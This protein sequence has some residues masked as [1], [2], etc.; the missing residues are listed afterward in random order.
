MNR[1][2]QKKIALLTNSFHTGGGLE[3]I[4]QIVRNLPEFQFAVFG[5]G[6][7]DYQKFRDLPHVQVIDS[8]YSPSLIEVYQPDLVHIHHLKPLLNL[9]GAPFRSYP[10]PI[11]FTIHGVH[12]HKYEFLSGIRHQLS[13]QLRFRLE[14]Y[15]YRKVNKLITVSADDQEFVRQTYAVDHLIYIPN[16]LDFE[17]INPQS[18]PS[19][20]EIR[21]QLSLSNSAFAF[22]TIARFDFAKGYDVLIK[23]LI[24]QRKELLR[25]N[26]RFLFL[27]NGADRKNVQRQIQRFDLDELVIFIDPE[28]PNYHLL[29]A[30]DAFILPSRWEGLPLTL[31]EAGAFSLPVLASETYGIRTIIQHQKNGLLFKNQNSSDLGQLLMWTLNNRDQFKRMGTQL[32]EDVRKNYDLK[33]TIELLRS[34]Y[35][36]LL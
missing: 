25:E 6:G 8:G 14:R 29:K 2:P 33:N 28:Y 36:S 19:R 17:Q 21:Q 15:L 27:G 18:L 10:F 1:N 22:L 30:S 12:L 26:C 9:L 5:K 4:Y 11:I 20:Q 23:S 3:H 31:L 24:R 32:S 13:F 35:C 16:G 7:E 34:V